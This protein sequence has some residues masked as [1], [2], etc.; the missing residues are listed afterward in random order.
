MSVVGVYRNEQGHQRSYEEPELLPPARDIFVPV[1]NFLVLGMSNRIA[2]HE[3]I[4][5]E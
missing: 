3:L 2:F 4:V 1:L 5:E